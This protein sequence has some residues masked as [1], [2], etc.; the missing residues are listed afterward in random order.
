MTVSVAGVY[1]FT[2]TET[3]GICTDNDAV[4][5]TF[6]AVPVI[7][8]GADASDCDLSYTLSGST[9]IGTGVWTSVPAAGVTFSNINDPLATV[10]VP[11][12]GTYT[13]TW[14]VTNGACVV[15][16]NVVLNF[17]Q[18]P[19]ADAGSDAS[20]CGLN[21]TLAAVPS[22]GSGAWTYTGPGIATFNSTI[23]A[24]ANVTVSDSGH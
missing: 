19:T 1:T 2:W 18:S 23:I 20:V 9:T 11:A 6:D 21:Y 3:N 13:L 17:L 24:N 22:V 7:T 14:T 4:D 5:I 10:T 12:T 15:A 8:A 16:D